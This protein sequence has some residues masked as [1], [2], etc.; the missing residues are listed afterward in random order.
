MCRRYGWLPTK[1]ARNR[2]RNKRRGRRVKQSRCRVRR[3]KEG[4]RGK[5]SLPQRAKA[6][7]SK[8]RRGIYDMDAQKP[9]P[10]RDGHYGADHTLFSV[11]PTPY[12][13]RGVVVSLTQ[14]SLTPLLW[15]RMCTAGYASIHPSIHPSHPP[16]HSTPSHQH[17]QSLPLFHSPALPYINICPDWQCRSAIISR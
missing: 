2:R 9:R 16:T 7:A 12:A 5:E 17:R 14:L 4:A 11:A 1:K 10:T 8:E 15:A 3:E 13:C 6:A